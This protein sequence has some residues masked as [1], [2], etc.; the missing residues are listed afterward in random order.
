MNQTVKQQAK[1]VQASV[2]AFSLFWT[3]F[4]YGRG[5]GFS[6]GRILTGKFQSSQLWCN[7][8][9]EFFGLWC[10]FPRTKFMMGQVFVIWESV[11][12]RSSLS[13]PRQPKMQLFSVDLFFVQCTIFQ[14]Q[15]RRLHKLFHLRK[16]SANPR[17]L[18]KRSIGENGV[19]Q[20]GES[21]LTIM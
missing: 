19:V 2:I 17:V 16:C 1:T 4:S 11:F 13:L 18:P 9:D 12:S 3:Q 20:K 21:V 6:T 15:L 5:E 14:Q 7:F 8:P 10:E